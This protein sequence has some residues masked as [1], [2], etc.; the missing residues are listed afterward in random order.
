LAGA[1]IGAAIGAF[2]GV[3]GT[4]VMSACGTGAFVGW[5]IGIGQ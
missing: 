5:L 1:I 3:P 4:A 2:A